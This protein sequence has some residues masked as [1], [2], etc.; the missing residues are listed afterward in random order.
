MRV[1]SLAI[2]QEAAK[3]M[4]RR[5]SLLFLDNSGTVIQDYTKARRKVVQSLGWR[6]RI[7][8]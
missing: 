2:M 5:L 4:Q 6:A 7:V 8:N 1:A 3:M